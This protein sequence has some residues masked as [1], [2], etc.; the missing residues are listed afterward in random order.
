V[1]AVIRED[2]TR[3]AMEVLELFCEL[4][5]TRMGLF[6]MK[7]CDTSI[8]E[9]VHTLIYA[10][11][12]AEVKELK[13]VRDQLASKFGRDFCENAMSNRLGFVNPRVAQK[14]KVSI[15][16]AYLVEQFIKDISNEFGIPYEEPS[17]SVK[18]DGIEYFEAKKLQEAP[19][20]PKPF[21]IPPEQTYDL[22]YVPAITLK[23]EV[24]S[25]KQ[26]QKLD[27]QRSTIPDLPDSPVKQQPPDIFK[28]PEPPSMQ[29]DE[30]P[31]FDELARRFEELKRQK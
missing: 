7:T 26:E 27:V 28:L 13:E 12:R 17:G 19:V 29:L 15:P 18:I 4:L 6:E 5:L 14:L 8:Q 3:E 23:K 30:N 21:Q 9:A 25:K 16:D 2:A 11:N 22:P 24:D 31:D 1:E 20:E 10:S